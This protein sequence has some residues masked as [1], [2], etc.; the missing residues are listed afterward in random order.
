MSGFF[1]WRIS[2]F[3]AANKSHN[4]HSMAIN[5]NIFAIDQ[6]IQLDNND[7]DD[8]DEVDFHSLEKND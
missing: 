4:T 8:D 1:P 5:L 7:D 3:N 2:L 6:S